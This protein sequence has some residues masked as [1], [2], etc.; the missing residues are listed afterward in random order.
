MSSSLTPGTGQAPSKEGAFSFFDDFLVVRSRVSDFRFCKHERYLPLDCAFLILHF[1]IHA[2]LSASFQM[3][4]GG[5][6]SH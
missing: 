6:N 2:I 4:F 3:K 1:S 5:D